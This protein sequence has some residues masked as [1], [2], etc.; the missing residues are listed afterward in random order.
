MRAPV[1]CAYHTEKHRLAL[2]LV[3]PID[4]SLDNRGICKSKQSL[5]PRDGDARWRVGV[6]DPIP[7]TVAASRLNPAH[8][9]VLGVPTG[10]EAQRQVS[11]LR[12]GEEW[13]MDI[14]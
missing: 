9:P 13:Y 4:R 8:L 11:A 2:G 10:K 7:L 6:V 1:W 14:Q 3:I 5:A 12:K